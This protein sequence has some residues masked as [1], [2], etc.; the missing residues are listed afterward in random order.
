MGYYA[1]DS[2]AL[3]ELCLN[4][5][6]GNRLRDALKKGDITA[7]THEIAWIEVSYVL[8]RKVGWETVKT[9]LTPS[10]YQAS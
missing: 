5:D 7:F 6:S 3:L 9:L 10:Y 1:I 2:G 8:C 4:S